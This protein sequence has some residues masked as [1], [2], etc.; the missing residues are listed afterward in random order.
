MR[1]AKWQVAPEDERRHARATRDAFQRREINLSRRSSGTY[2]RVATLRCHG[3]PSGL[4][5]GEGVNVDVTRVQ[6]ARW[7]RATPP[8][9]TSYIE[10]RMLAGPDLYFSCTRK[11]HLVV[12]HTGLSLRHNRIPLSRSYGSGLYC[13]GRPAR[14]P[15]F[16]IETKSN[17]PSRA[18]PS[19]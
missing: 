5:R 1:G 7:S 19:F 14:I 8:G 17:Y 3:E 13:P 18:V 11:I 10:S 9:P 16:R 6:H 2:A 15:G 4:Q 12:R